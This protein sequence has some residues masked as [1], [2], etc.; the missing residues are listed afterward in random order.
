MA[1]T[2]SPA[3]RIELITTG[4]QSGTWGITTDVNLGTLIEN[5]ISGYS[6]VTQG[7][8]A[9]Y[10]LTTVNG[11]ADQ[12]RNMIL[13][14]SGALTA[15]RNVICPTFNKMYIIKNATTGGFNVIIKTLAG[16]GVTIPSGAT[17]VVY[18]DGVNVV[19]ASSTIGL[20]DGS[21]A[22]PSLYLGTN[23]TTGIYKKAINSLGFSSAGVE[24]FY[25]DAT[26]ANGIIGAGTAF[27]GT[28][29]TATATTITGT[30]V[31]ATTFSGT[32]TFSGA[33]TA[34]TAAYGTNTTQIAT[35]A[36]GQAN[37]TG[38]TTATGA[39]IIPAGTTAQR[40]AAPVAGYL[41]WNN[42][43]TAFE[44][45]SGAA[46]TSV[47]GGATGA[48]GDTV[49]VENSRIVTTSYTLSTG[50]NASCV[51]PITVNTGVVLTIPTGARLV[52]L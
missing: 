35:T 20:A 33:A 41:R 46:W 23:S 10:T 28:F 39:A 31:A 14:I 13:N 17:N 2:Y 7:D 18:C 6:N 37:F 29:T 25:I 40:D 5:A 43:V 19:S 44:G 36:Y 1:S 27:A 32:P 4:E 50:K 9:N 45:W 15:D 3:L 48:G 12:A 11:A 16:T 34:L 21:A 47:G 49:F 52:V 42:T 38:K 26:G 22:L 24:K 51:G 30:T 8:V